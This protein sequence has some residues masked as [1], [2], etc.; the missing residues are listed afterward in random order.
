M[1]VEIHPGADEPI[2]LGGV[3]DGHLDDGRL[4]AREALQRRGL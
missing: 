1:V 4:L 2:Q 3:G